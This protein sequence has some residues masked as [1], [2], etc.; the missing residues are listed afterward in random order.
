MKSSEF[1]AI[2]KNIRKAHGFNKT[3]EESQGK[4]VTTLM[5]LVNARHLIQHDIILF[6]WRT[7][8]QFLSYHL[9]IN[10][11]KSR[12]T[13]I[14]VKPHYGKAVS[15]RMQNNFNDVSF[16]L[17]RRKKAKPLKILNILSIVFVLNEISIYFSNDIA[18]AESNRF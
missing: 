16:S 4:S 7:T 1:Y 5:S 10:R 12:E 11:G 9:K 18:K 17:I 13:A 6:Q 14:K 2:L 8:L 3:L 15:V